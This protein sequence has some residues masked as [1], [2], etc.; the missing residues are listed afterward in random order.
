MPDRHQQVNPGDHEQHQL[1]SDYGDPATAWTLKVVP[2]SDPAWHD[3]TEN[4]IRCI[5]KL[6]G[7]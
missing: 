4:S 1:S 2:D 6:T 7:T 5:G 3:K